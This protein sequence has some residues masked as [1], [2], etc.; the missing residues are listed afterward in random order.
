MKRIIH[1]INRLFFPKRCGFCGAYIPEESPLHICPACM[2]KLPVIHGSG[3]QVLK[4]HMEFVLSPFCYSETVRSMVHK[5]K[6]ENKPMY[7][8]TLAAFMAERLVKVCDLAQIDMVVPVPMT[9]LKESE[10]GYNTAQLLA[11]DIARRCDLVLEDTLLRKV[12]ETKP[13][14]SLKSHEDRVLNVRDAFA[15]RRDIEDKNVLLVD[16]IYTTGNTAKNC[17]KA[18]KVAGA[19]KIWVLT[20]AQAHAAQAKKQVRFVQIRDMVFRAE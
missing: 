16:D 8:A 13:Q 2:R 18:L 20:A 17:A 7:A 1:W 10:R 19:G 3:K 5:M 11:K 4:G 6:F 14:S 15:C 12:R 9:R